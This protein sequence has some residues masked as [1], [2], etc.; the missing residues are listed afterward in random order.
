[1]IRLEESG[2][3]GAVREQQ[4]R[5][6]ARMARHE[7]AQVVL[8]AMDGRD[9]LILLLLGG[10]GGAGLHAASAAPAAAQEAAAL[11][12]AFE[13]ARYCTR[14]RCAQERRK[15]QARDRPCLPE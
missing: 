9:A 14:G 12:G 8:A 4:S 6:S 3:V 15:Q 7:R 1:M 2:G 11:E 13:A 10:G 5:W